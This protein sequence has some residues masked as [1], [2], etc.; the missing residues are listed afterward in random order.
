METDHAAQRYVSI[1]TNSGFK[2]V[3]G[4]RRNKD[5]IISI[6]NTLL[7][8]H[9]QVMD[10]QYLP[11]EQQ[12]QT[13]GN[14][15]Y[16]YDFICQD[17]TGTTFIVEAQCYREDYWFRRCVSYASRMYDRQASKGQGYDIAPVYLIGLMGVPIRHQNESEWKDRY[18][19]EYTFREKDSHDL[20]DETIFI[21]FA[22]LARFNKNEQECETDLDR[23]CYILK[24]SGNLQNPPV[25]MR[26]NNIFAELLRA[27]EIGGFSEDKRIIY[28]KDM[29][30]ERRIYS[31][32]QTARRIGLEQGLADG[33]AK[34]KTEGMAEGLTKGMAKG[35]AEGLALIVNTL[36]SKGMTAE[37][38]AEL[39]D[40]QLAE[41]K[42]LLAKE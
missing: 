19:S 34:G 7:P 3:F 17:K 31:E 21:I 36:S 16:R 42:E 8:A 26:D 13:T 41:V 18:I 9:R 23:M 4:D 5:V 25:W 2:A 35:R 12:G 22:E 37:E 14:K 39:T 15:E 27:C 40:L 10:I 6:I 32:L 24:N 33:I 29:D 38:I 11:T 28:D 20:L 1:L 30:D